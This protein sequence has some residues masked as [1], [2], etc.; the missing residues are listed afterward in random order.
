MEKPKFD[1][2]QILDLKRDKNNMPDRIIID[3]IYIKRNSKEWMYYVMSEQ[4]G[5][6]TYLPES[7]L[8]SMV[9]YHIRECYKNTIV[10]TLYKCGFRFV[11]NI[12][13]SEVNVKVSKLQNIKEIANIIV[14]PAVYPDGTD[15]IGISAIWIRYNVVI[16]D[17]LDNDIKFR[18]IK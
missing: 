5:G 16:S 6:H 15:G 1:I 12:Q 3:S 13:N 11:C 10:K 2:G 18:I 9:S 14:A 4:T 7:K 8:S 17:T